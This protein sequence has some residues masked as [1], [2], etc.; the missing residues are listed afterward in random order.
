MPKEI[1]HD[2]EV[3]EVVDDDASAAPEAPEPSIRE[4]IA[5][6]MEASGE[7]SGEEEV[8]SA[9]P[10]QAHTETEEREE[11][12]L[13]KIS[14][15]TGEEG[16][17]ET[18]Q[19]ESLEPPTFWSQD[20]KQHW[21]T[22]PREVQQYLLTKEKEANADYTRRT[23]EAAEL[24]KRYEPLDEILRPHEQHWALNGQSPAQVVNQLLAADQFIKQDPYNAVRW[25]IQ[26]NGLDPQQI[27]DPDA[28]SVPPEV[29]QLNQ[30]IQGLESTIQRQTA[31]QQQ[32]LLESKTKEV[33]MFFDQKSPEGS[34]VFPFWRD[35][36]G[37]IEALL[38]TLMSQNSGASQ[39]EL[40]KMAYDQAVYA[41]PETRKRVQDERE[42]QAFEREKKQAAERAVKAKRAAVS[43]KGRSGGM[44]SKEVPSTI[45][46]ILEQQF[47]DLA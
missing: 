4:T 34:E 19:A 14:D 27:V 28:Y 2:G 26:Q 24:R 15:Q 16:E 17:G 23:Q 9:S 18:Q 35:V 5:A 45:R 13:E 40:L 38:P 30:R 37:H 25:L 11:D 46:G 10:G 39:T 8:A 21:A 36:T 20:A 42:R 32:Q 47:G 33:E 7:E 43:V 12:S 41:N 44:D 3:Y 6:A 1:E 22:I 31:Q 29:M